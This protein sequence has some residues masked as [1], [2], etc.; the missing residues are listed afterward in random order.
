MPTFAIVIVDGNTYKAMEEFPSMSV[1]RS[2]V[3]RSAVQML[4]EEETVE[5]KR[6]ADCRIEE[7]GGGRE[8]SFKINLEIVDFI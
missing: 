1:A 6:I 8:V 2:A 5:G 7:I 4:L 3:A